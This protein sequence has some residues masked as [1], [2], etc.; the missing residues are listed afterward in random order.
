MI[1]NNDIENTKGFREET[2]NCVEQFRKTVATAIPDCPMTA[3]VGVS[4][5]ERG[6]DHQKWHS[7]VKRAVNRSKKE[8][9]N[10][11]IYAMVKV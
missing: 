7:S 5:F 6:D 11:V 9:G 3:S 2:R 10:K 4:M 8:G 1:D